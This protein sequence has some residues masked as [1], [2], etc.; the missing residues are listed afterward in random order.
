MK[1]NK[2]NNEITDGLL[3]AYINGELDHQ[4]TGKVKNWINAHEANKQRYEAIKK[5]WDLTGDLDPVPVEVNAEKAWEIVAEKLTPPSVKI[6]P[7]KKGNKNRRIGMSIAAAI[8]LA[9]CSVSAIRFINNQEDIVTQVATTKTI[10]DQLSDGSVVKLNQN[11]RLIYPA[12]FSANERRVKL[13]GE[14]FF[15]VE[16]D[17]KKPFIIDLP[18]K[19]YVK[20]LGTSFIIKA[21]KNDSITEVFV[22][23]G[24]VEFGTKDEKI[25]L[26]A[27]EK[28]IMNN[29]TG[30]VYKIKNNKHAGLKEMYW[31]NKEIK[32]EGTALKDVVEMLNIIFDDQVILECNSSELFPIRSEFRSESLDGILAVIAS[33]H[34][35]KLSS[36]NTKENNKKYRLDCND[37]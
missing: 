30:T 17:T 9:I 26:V 6:V 25:V 29:L 8:I 34:N 10:T 33:T 36:T 28:G 37:N 15:E 3:L 2:K 16:R 18:N 20:V 23:T 12:S 24:K 27:G 22:N 35:L 7:L 19:A 11:S 1:E 13:Q 32:F 5:T 4:L 21:V 14:A 31:I